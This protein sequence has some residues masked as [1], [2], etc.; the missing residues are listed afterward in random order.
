MNGPNQ[1]STPQAG[2]VASPPAAGLL[3]AT[4]Q[5]AKSMSSLS[6]LG[7]TSGNGIVACQASSPQLSAA[8]GRANLVSQFG[9]PELKPRRLHHPEY[10]T[11][12]SQIL[13]VTMPVILV[14]PLS[15]THPPHP[16]PA[17]DLQT[18]LSLFQPTHSQRFVWCLTLVLGSLLLVWTIV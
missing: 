14:L 18:L 13:K 10:C 9:E 17:H 15:L 7:K 3:H 11:F 8:G 2:V 12:L 6:N 16:G 5:V 1:A 4:L